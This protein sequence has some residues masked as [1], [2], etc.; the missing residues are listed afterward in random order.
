MIRK[1]QMKPLRCLLS[2]VVF[3]LPVLS[4]YPQTDSITSSKETDQLAFYSG[5]GYGS[6]M[7]WLGSTIS[8][9]QPYGYGAV[10]F[11]LFEKFTVSGSAFYLPNLAPTAPA[12]YNASLYFNHD[13]TSWL[14]ISAGIYRYMVRPELADTLFGTFNYADISLGVDWKILFT[15]VNYGA[16]VMK[17]PPAYIQVKNSRYFETPSFFRKKVNISFNPY[18]NILFGNLVTSQI[19]EGT[20]L[21][22]ST[23]TFLTPVTTAI[24]SGTGMGHGSGSGYGSRS[25]AGQGS[26]STSGTGAA[27]TTT[28]STTTTITT[29]T[30]EVPTTT[31]VYSEN[32]DLIEME[33]GLPVSLN[34]DFMSLEAEAGYVLPMYSNLSYPGPKGFVFTISVFF[35]IF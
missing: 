13:I 28:T 27:T 26:G 21:I 20:E 9:N 15:E 7:I 32:F 17:D 1:N 5:A 22:T 16:F 11:S 25:A 30:T 2:A 33:F 3:I 19:F 35:K 12:F 10:A 14:D 31:T 34:L 29:T 6:N 18:V 4:S 8:R 24:T 23:Q